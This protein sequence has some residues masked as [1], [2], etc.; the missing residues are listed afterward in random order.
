MGE[1]SLL[2]QILYD[3][4]KRMQ[5]FNSCGLSVHIGETISFGQSLSSGIV[6][7]HAKE[8]MWYMKRMSWLQ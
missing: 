4:A 2:L 8:W 3:T 6:P 7:V 1:I 5:V